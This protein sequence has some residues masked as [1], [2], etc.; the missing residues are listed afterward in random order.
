MNAEFLQQYTALQNGCGVVRLDNWSSITLTGSDRQKFLHNFCTNDIKRLPPGNACEAFFLNVKGKIVGHGFVSCRAD[1]LVVI[2]VPGQAETLIA[3]LDRYLI[4]ED[5]QLRDTT[6]ERGYLLI[7]GQ[8]DAIEAKKSPP[9]LAGGDVTW[10][11]CQIIGSECEYLVESNSPG[12]ATLM[13]ACEQ[14]GAVLA[15]D[16]FYAA[17]IEAGTPLFMVDFDDHN[18]PQEVG[19]DL[20]AISFTKGCYLGQE[21]VARIDAIGHV[22]Q[23]LVGVR[24]LSHDIFPEMKLSKGESVIGRVTSFAFSP[25]A[26]AP[27]GLATVR[28]EM[29][30][31]GTRLDSPAG[32]CE[33]VALPLLG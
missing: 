16:A 29:S 14:F 15:N 7:A 30:A 31:V 2:G 9:I 13:S 33:V 26:N 32:E 8:R 1:E 19:R 28:S 24:F 10:I 5:V 3:H 27:L 21:T 20:Q 17:R 22:N 6:Q 23:R 18:L 11:P 12:S 4:R 25:R